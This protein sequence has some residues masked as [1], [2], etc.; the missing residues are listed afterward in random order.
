MLAPVD[1]TQVRPACADAIDTGASGIF[2]Y[3]QEV[4]FGTAEAQDRMAQWPQLRA[5]WP[6]KSR[7][8]RAYF[9]A[10]NCFAARVSAEAISIGAMASSCSNTP[11]AVFE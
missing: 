9:S 7:S 5:L 2:G 11:R 3:L 10:R 6:R 8:E 4:K 1:G